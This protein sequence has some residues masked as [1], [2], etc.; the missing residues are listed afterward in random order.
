M[1]V[2]EK[3]KRDDKT[4]DAITFQ[5][6]TL[7]PPETLL[8]ELP[9]ED[10]LHKFG[11]K[12]EAFGPI[13]YKLA[14]RGYHSFIGGMYQAYSDHRP[15][16]ISPDM[17]WLLICQGFS[18]HVNF[19]AQ[20][21]RDVFPDLKQQPLVIVNDKIKLGMLSSPW[22]ETS[23]QFTDQIRSYI[24]DELIDALQA[25]FSTTKLTERIASEIT[26][27]DAMKPY[28]KYIVGYCICGIPQIT[29]EGNQND[30][31]KILNK[32]SVLKKYN[33]D[34]WVDTLE[35]I[36]KKFISALNGTIDKEFWMNMF[37]VHTEDEYGDPK[38]IDGWITKFYPYDKEGNRIDLSD[39]RFIFIDSF[40]ELLPK[41]IV[42]VDFEYQIINEK[43][44]VVQKVPME[45]WAGFL[46]LKQNK[47]NFQIR[48]EIGWFVSYRDNSMKNESKHDVESRM[49][50]YYNLREFP[51]DVLLIKELEELTLMFNGEILIPDEI[52]ELQMDALNLTGE[53]IEKEKT[54]LIHLFSKKN[55]LLKING[56]GFFKGEPR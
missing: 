48:P 29:I 33:L 53:I 23:K 55:M 3:I 34:W 31:Q 54:R 30:W 26:I 36:I 1:V 9:L 12:I 15:F 8:E 45:Y 51:E 2:K 24:G 18:T 37:K 14:P 40:Y 38:R 21:K 17:I 20:I 5:V 50:V 4:I 19:N 35:P 13:D 32:L 42:C 25:D 52:L 28:F 47:E 46:G 27:M 56:E 39:I 7:D 43:G 6:E 11:S 16:V 41:E 49:K 44:K 10:I 22:E